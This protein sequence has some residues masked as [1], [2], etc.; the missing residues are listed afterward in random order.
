VWLLLFWFVLAGQVGAMPCDVDNDGDIDL[1]DLT[2]I[3]KSILA[4]AAVTGQDDPRDPDQNGLINSIDGRLCALRCTRAK[5]STVN[6]APF[7]NAGPDQTVKVGD[8]VQLSG[9]ASSDPDGD[10]LRYTWTFK[11]HPLGSLAS[12]IDGLTVA[13]RFTA[14]KPGQY[15]IQLIVSDGK[16][17]SVP[18][19]V[20]VSTENS[21]PI[22]NAGPD[23][24]VR[25]G[26]LVMLN[27]GRSTDVDGDPLTYS[28]QLA[29]APPR[30]GATL[31]NPYTVN[32]TLQIDQ[33]GSYLIALTVSDGKVHG[34]PDSVTVA[35][36]N[37][38]PVA[39]PG[40]NQSIPL[41]ATITL[42]GSRSSDVD[43]NPLTFRWSLL[44]RSPGSAAVLSNPNSVTPSFNADAP[45]TYVAQLIVNDGS[46]D[47]APAS[48]TLT[49]ANAAPIANAGPDQSV[50]LGS[51]ATLDGSASRD[52][53]GAA[54]TY[55]WSLTG[56]PAGSAASLNGSGTVNP[57]F[58][59]D[60]PGNYIAQLIVGDGQLASAPDTVTLST[61]NSRP[62]ADAGGA[63]AVTAGAPVQLDGSASRDADGD[64]ITFTWS[65]TSLPPGSNAAIT[66]SHGVS[67]SFVP[68]LAGAYIA[69]LIVSDG[70]LN[71]VPATVVVT[72]SAANRKPVAVAEAIPTQT[73]VGSPV[74]LKGSASSDP[75]GDPLTWSW[76]IALRPGGSNAGIVSPTAA[77][78]SF[79]PDLPGIYTIQLIVRDG[80]A[81]S[82]P[83]LV[84]VEALAANH[85]PVITSTPVITA[86]VG[87]PY[88]YAAQAIDPDLGDVLTWSLL[89]APSG[90]SID[91]VSGLIAWTPTAADAGQLDVSVQVR[92]SAGLTARQ[93]FRIDVATGNRAPVA[94]DDSYPMTSGQ[95]VTV[96]ARGALANDSDP[97]GNP[98]TA[99]IAREPARGTVTLN[100]DGS[101]SYTPTPPAPVPNLNAR[102]KW[103]WTS[104]PV[105]PDSL[106]VVMTPSVIDLDADGIPDVVFGSTDSRGGGF[107]EIG[108]LRALSGADG[109]ELFT[110]TDTTL[111]INAFSQIAVADIDSDGRPEIILGDAS[112]NRLVAFE[113]DGT[114]KWRSPV[115]EDISWGGPAIADLDGDG[116]PEII[117]GRQVLNAD[118]SLRWTGTGGR[119]AIGFN[120][121]L[122]PLSVV[123]D[124][125]LDGIPEVVAGNT[126]Y[127]PDGTIKWQAPLT[128]GFV[129]LGNFDDDP[130]PEIVLVN[131]GGVFL[132][133]HDGTTKWGPVS[134]PG[135][136]SGGPPTVADFDGDGRPEIG[137]AG[138]ARY[139]VYETDGSVKWQSITQDVSSNVTG[140]SVF[141]FEGD[142]SAE[143]VYRDELKL[144]VYRGRDGTVLF[145]YPLSSCT[146]YE[147]MPIVDVDADGHAEIVASATNCGTFGPQRGI[148]VFADAG[149]G[150]APTRK[151]WNQHSYHITNVNE[152]GTIPRR[153]DI[154]W[155]FPGLNNF[156]LNAYAPRDTA[157]ADSFTYRAS[158]GSLQSNEATVRLILQRQNRQPVF[159]SAPPLT[160]TTGQSYTYDAN[161]IDPDA[162]DTLIFSLTTAPAGMTIHSTTGLISWAPTA[163]QVGSHPITVRVT[164]QGGL[165][166]DQGY[167][168]TVSTPA[169][170]NRAPTITS[171]APTIA[172]AGAAYTYPVTATDPDAGDV[173]TWSLTA[174]PTGMT[175]DPATG[176]I[177][178]TPAVGQVG[179]NTVSVRV[180]DQGGLFATEGFT[181]SVAVPVNQP[182]IAVDDTYA[183]D[184]GSSLVVAGGAP[185]VPLPIVT[186]HRVQV[187]AAM[188]RPIGLAFDA[189]GTLYV[190]ADE[191]SAFPNDPR[192]PG[193]VR[194]VSP[195]GG[196]VQPFG[197]LQDD[198][199]AL[200]VDTTGRISGTSG[201]LLVSGTT[202]IAHDSHLTAILPDG[203]TRRVL[204]PQDFQANA[205]AILFDSRGRLLMS[206]F[207]QGSYRVLVIAQGA[208]T[209]LVDLGSV[210]PWDIAVDA[211]DRIFVA[212]EDGIIRVFEADGSLVNA[213]FASGQPPMR[214]LT[215]DPGGAF[216]G[217]LY[218]I[219]G[220]GRLLRIDTLGN[221]TEVGSGFD[222]VSASDMVFGPDRALYVSEVGRG[223]VLR[224]TLVQTPATAGGVLANDSDPD[225]DGLNA[226][227]VTQPA[228][229]ILSFAPNGA[230]VYTPKAGFE[231][232]DSFSYKANDGQLD[233][234]VA[235]VTITVQPVNHPPVFISAPILSAIA[236]QPYSYDANATDPDAG[237]ALVFSLTTAPAGM[238]I[239]STTGLISWTPLV[240]E[241]G[242]QNVTVRVTDAGGLF[243]EQNFRLAIAA[244]VNRPPVAVDDLFSVSEGAS[245]S[246]GSGAV[247]AEPVPVAFGYRVEVYARLQAPVQLTFDPAGVLYAGYD[248]VGNS[249]SP[250]DPGFVRRIARGGTPVTNFGPQQT[251]PDAVVVD[252][253]GS[254][255]GVA[256]AVLVSGTTSDGSASHLSAILPDGTARTL[257]SSPQYVANSSGM[258]F[259]RRGRLL[260]GDTGSVAIDPKRVLISEGAV[261]KELFPVDNSFPVELAVDPAN[262]I[263]V[264]GFFGVIRIYGEDGAL[265]DPAFVSGLGGVKAM[266]FG[267]GGDFGNALYVV[268]G[269]GRLLRVGNGGQIDVLGTG[270]DDAMDIV[271]GPDF[272]MYLS[273]Y[274]RGR[275]LRITATQA[276]GA[277][278]SVLAN[279]T[280]PE[281]DVLNAILM[282]Q[283]VNGSLSFGTNGAFTYTPMAGFRGM[284]SFTYKANDG[285]LDSNVA[286]VTITVQPVNHPPV[287]TS[288]PI[289]SAI[290]GQP[291]SYDANATDPD[292][293]DALAY[294]LTTAPPG[295]QINP[296]TG[297]IDWTPAAAQIG[298]HPVTVRV[299]DPGGLFD[300]QSFSINVSAPPP[301]NLPPAFTSTPIITATVGQPY[302]YD[303]NSTDDLT[304]E[305]GNLLLNGSFEQSSVNGPLFASS[306]AITHWTVGGVTI[307]YTSFPY[308]WNASDGVFS[309]DLEG[310][311]GNNSRGTIFQAFATCPGQPYRVLFD[312]SGNPAS[313]PLVKRVQVT[314]AADSMT[315]EYDIGSVGWVANATTIRY[316]LKEFQFTATGASTTLE[317]GSLG[318]TG[319]GPVIDNVRVIPVNGSLAYSLPTAP[320]GMTIDSTT[321]LISWTPTDVQAGPQNVTVRVTDP[322][323]LTDEQSFSITVS[324]PPPVN[325]PPAFTSSPI[326]TATVG[327]P[328]TYDAGATDTNTGDT[329]TFSLPAAPAG[330]GINPATG[331][332]S[333]T[334]TNTQVGSQAVTVRVTDPGGLTDEQSFSIT[335]SA[336][337]PVNLPPAFTSTPATTATV[338]QPYAYDADATDPGDTL[339]YSLTTAP[340]GM[341]IAAATG[342][343]QWTPT[344]AQAGDH[345]VEVKVQ[346]AGGLFVTQPF[347]LTVSATAVCVPPP[348]GLISWW[349]GDGNTLDRA[350]ANDGLAENGASYAAGLVGQAFRFDGVDDL[351]RIASSSTVS[352]GGPFSVEFWFN[353][354]TTINVSTPN[355]M[356]LAKGRYLEGGFN[357]PVAIQVLGG[358]GRLLVRMPPAPA[359]VTTTGTWPAGTWQHIA[360]SW[361]GARYR[362]YV[363]GSEEAGLDN[364]FSIFDSSDPITLGNADGFAAGGFAGLLDEPTLYNRALTPAEVTA[365]HAARGLGK[366][367]ATYSRADAGPDQAVEVAATVSLDGSASRAFDGAALAYQW[368][369]TSRPANSTAILANP[370]TVSPSFTADKAGAYTLEL[371][372]S[373]AGRASAPDSVSITAAKVN[374]P[375]SIT[376][377]AITA[378][379][380][381]TAYT[382][383]VTASDPDPGDTLSF[384]L[385]T[386]PAG[387]SINA[388]SGLI[389]WTPNAGQIGSHPVSVR[390]QDQGGLFA[391]QIFLLIVVAAPVPVTVP[392]VVGQEQAAAQNAISAASLTVGTVTVAASDTV[393]AGRVISQNPAAG[394]VVNSGSAVALVVSS[395]PQGPAVT[396]IRVTPTA[397][398]LL[399]GQTQAFAATGIL[400]NG[401]SLP[402]TSGLTWTSS[403]PA[404]AS[405]DVNGLSTALSQGSTT[406]SASQGGIT[407]SATFTVAQSVPDA[408][409][410]IA[411]ITAPAD[412]ASIASAVPIVG[413]ASDANFLKYL[414]EIAPFETGVFS[415]LHVGTAPVTGGTLA[416]LDPTTLVNDLYV[417]RLTVI[418]KADNRTQTEIT[419]Q[420]TRDKK[421]GNFTLAF[422]DLNVPMAGIPISVVRSYDSRD[423][424]RGDF[425]IGWRLDVQSLRLR[426][427]G[428]PGD[429]WRINRTGGVLNRLYS[430]KETRAHKVAITLPDGKVEE[431]TLTPVPDSQRLSTLD[432]T[433][434]VYSP[435][436]QTSGR[437]QPVGGTDL[438]VVGAQPGTV[439]LLTPGYELYNPAEYEYTTP[440]GQVILISR[441]AGVKQIRDRSG[442]TVSFAPGGIIHSAGKSITFARDGQGRITTVTDP[443]G[444]AQTYA[445]DINGDLA[446]HTDAEGR[447]T[448]F[449]YN[450]EHGLIEIQDPRGV[451]PIRNEYDAAGRLIKTIDAYGKEITYTHDL[452][453]NRE[454]I[455]DR[456]GNTTI[457]VYDDLGNVTQTADPLG[458]VTNRSYDGRGNTLSET[459]PLGRT[460]T[461]TY[462]GQD[463][464]LT[465]TDPLGQTTRYTYNNSRQVLT[466]T[467]AL[468]RITSNAYDANGNLT[469]STDPAG[470][471]TTYTYDAR[472][473]QNTRTDP[474]GQITS[475]AYDASGNLASETDA[476]GRVTSYTY[477]ANGNRLT[478]S[479]T[480]S[481][482]GGPETLT[483]R[484][485]YDK[486]NRL[487]ET[488]HPD[489]S[490][491]R[492]AYN[493]I[494]KQSVTTDPL[495]RETKF[496]YD[497]MGRL[498]RSTYPDGSSE[499]S[500]YDAEGRRTG[501][502]DR[503]GRTTT[504]T[505][506]QL[507][508]LIET[509]A[510]D[511]SRTR[512]TY[513]AAGQVLASTDARGNVTGYEY[514]AAGRRSKVTD[515]AGAATLFTY[516]AL[517]NQ[518]QVTDANGHS[519]G[520]QY[521]ANNRRTRTNYADGTFELVVYDALG[522]QTA[523]T[524]QAGVTTQYGY[525][526][527]GRLISVTDALGQVTRYS[528][529]EQGNQ[530][531]QTDAEGRTTSFAY[532]KMGRRIRRTLP[533][534]QTETFSYD[535]AGNLRTKTDFNGRTTS[536]T[537]DT[538]NRLTRKTPD[539]SLGQ[540]PVVFSYTPSGQRAS[541]QDASGST[542]YSYDNR[543]RLLSKATPQ[544]TLSYSYDPAGNLTRIQSNHAGGAAMDYAYDPRN[545]LATVTD[546]EGR[547]TTYSYDA[548]GNLAGFL[549]PN[550]VQTTYTYNPLNRLTNVTGA[551]GGT[552]ASYTYTLGPSGNRTAVTEAS[553]RRVDY[554]YDDLYRLRSETI[555]ADPTGPNGAIAYTYDRVG[556]RLTRISTVAG[557]PEQNFNYDFND[558]LD[559]E[560]YDNN[561]NTLTS[562]G[563]TFGYDFE[564]HL[565]SADGGVTFVYDGDGIRVA[566][567]AGG[568]TTGFLVDDRNPTGYAQVL[569]ELVGGAVER[570]Y[571]YG[572]KLISQKQASGVSFYGYDGHGSV[573]YLTD[574]SGNVT[575]TYSYE[576]FGNLVGQMSSTANVYLYA[577]EQRD[578]DVGFYYL[579]ARYHNSMQGRFLS[580]DP[581]SGVLF[582]PP[583]LHRYLYTANDPIGKA[584]PTGE[585]YTLTELGLVSAI[586]GILGGLST[587]V[588]NYALGR[589][590]TKASLAV[591][592]VTGAALGPLS[593]LY[594]E[595]GALA[596]AYG[597]VSSLGV[598]VEVFLS[599]TST[600]GQKAAAGALVLATVAGA[601]VAYK[602]L[603]AATGRVPGLPPALIGQRSV[604]NFILFM[605]QN[606]V[607]VVASEIFVRSPFQPIGRR[608]DVVLRD[609]ATQQL[610]GIEIKA[611]SG[612]FGRLNRA[613]ALSDTVVLRFGSRAFG[614]RARAAGIEGEPIHNVYRIQ[615]ADE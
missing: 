452:G 345:P 553:G 419:V 35:T 41:G 466:V 463:N 286:V 375:P 2:L 561:G 83:A 507:G 313:F 540:P 432:A 246:V 415:T 62:V 243:A 468:G 500:A 200:I 367:T 512:T 298:S 203:T 54:L 538:V 417:V 391:P 193:F 476:L 190:G 378:G 245:I 589:P 164:D 101:F 152:D 168:I 427:T 604:D 429:G 121:R 205:S 47:S 438:I 395:G 18:D 337:P 511:G 175:I 371:I 134:I 583:S 9:A 356:L 542:T 103:S 227:L 122:G 8:P 484:F 351:I 75:D 194:R 339:T 601:A 454:L 221:T 612:A 460:R 532:D 465:E 407:G 98:I 46:V 140:S 199:D 99:S 1:N 181:V 458:G 608:F 61:T 13:P 185:A 275:V 125:D 31:S 381:G 508:R 411:E 445:Y 78:T 252:V 277:Q 39:N 267:T 263:F 222:T 490:V 276:A 76:S 3:Q 58:T 372:V 27:G 85:P 324:A 28:W 486:A 274:V 388:A 176:L 283:P 539:G 314:A 225:G 340:P 611:T 559:G 281:G 293:G 400:A 174:A 22:A 86:T 230:F 352:F 282:T 315:F 451:R 36:E 595:I 150:W 503:A 424:T 105:L 455:T 258:V 244:P 70:Q 127:R 334:P 433:S 549:Y 531:T 307:D 548:V 295:M 320:A 290:A 552:L 19:T 82:V 289:L 350:A 296:A 50:P 288:A 120:L 582:D 162:A 49:T 144:R 456:L 514:D 135:G 316:V 114:F 565:T 575:D 157:Q 550:G 141:D 202:E 241:A 485:T 494:G 319:Y 602:Y 107:V 428:I 574:V 523:K 321:G 71:S 64:P 568:V 516:D 131:G 603:D 414:I 270:F 605:R 404:V 442:N 534:G 322:G 600:P 383:P 123:A 299:T 348:A 17:D 147:Y 220:G 90:M 153:E 363:N 25:V 478:Q 171:T 325:L 183:V 473:L 60:R 606:N 262:R 596:V 594:A 467:D 93:D 69:Q 214:A 234:N 394:S 7:A 379:A 52:P 308:H 311:N 297:V 330:M 327:Q 238:T 355:Q 51:S 461:T 446:S 554:T 434:A 170:T 535:A 149:P 413:T 188:E 551:R 590:T 401:S 397:P 385:T 228:S 437:L 479:T 403:N 435:G 271:F 11:N 517:G 112:G 156:R 247:P 614:A 118:G 457:H 184:E 389:Q 180:Q 273:E 195:G 543:D 109:R 492:V 453:A 344:A 126:V 597:T 309:I 178:W 365:L 294:S 143:V 390:V 409:L 206:D 15:L 495:G 444:N 420:I 509:I 72:V 278:G 569:E 513:D 318:S 163:A 347:T 386:A 257:F 563:R 304:C 172:T 333:W 14:D 87:Q 384:S 519:I 300:E 481:T 63:Q 581:A 249:P 12:L 142:G 496:D 165:F 580:N 399:T 374:H 201:A 577:G 331:L 510:P 237:D 91:P 159:T 264:A 564:N 233:S 173:L 586:G 521:D 323:G 439:Q 155:L 89:T 487:T 240:G 346:D 21:R 42:D 566:K 138:A 239:N 29:S 119:G 416:T 359:L 266:A 459:D 242:N 524:D 370:T 167:G 470:Q 113:H 292:A 169:P 448:S 204:G 224:I 615:W 498:T 66:P 97:D 362:L 418:D 37:S 80:K 423:K 115:L 116:Q 305:N 518:I 525:D 398:L 368:T 483:T 336:P 137:V 598:G 426:V 128:D 16:L 191:I 328:Y 338:G 536:Y 189:A 139:V 588:A 405:I 393:A 30:S 556:N 591:G 387:M 572:L 491:T 301:V 77:Q 136:G 421:V 210:A 443:M 43:G 430:L 610:V 342:L 555:S 440:E 592:I 557:I 402:L 357:A 198:P 380:V 450:Y 4:R 179:A 255:T 226:I 571:T 145:E 480:R 67:P 474:L 520:F 81:D 24:S 32:P 537:Y 382:Y 213:S 269:G 560:G 45:G 545:R 332:I 462:D 68:D 33:P 471:A 197:P 40:A 256:G 92:D 253:Q 94:L 229:G 361:D 250:Y 475:Y 216:A 217:H 20:I 412:G 482:A 533:L 477:D 303:V 570:S 235:M 562:G 573:R 607:E 504:S 74:V 95:P 489:G 358:D 302:T 161:A 449:L 56:R 593:L 166:A 306:T 353:P 341:V 146:G 151:I 408:T 53:E 130:F 223:Q 335:V 493:A 527:L 410:P 73:T 447:R 23:Q 488:T 579:R 317:F 599:D 515:A 530:L 65:L 5:C 472:G 177:A 499:T 505:Y 192:D 354:T 329:L 441:T 100:A 613:Q 207:L 396:A 79:V 312:L 326:T 436:A 544:G 431:F 38:P 34:L 44:A 425:G 585:K 182:P 88:S 377:T 364:A 104:S 259:D 129:A 369:L 558:R 6:Q 261:P 310:S 529:D 576:A 469:S 187:Y 291:Y 148:H 108:A 260:I 117:M 584:D 546:A 251:D 360:L 218:G 501:S 10:P 102:L 265:I 124:T 186:G 373:N 609:P 154:N 406:I 106:N 284:D 285:Q 366:C 541:M 502:T 587:R 212:G 280:D 349:P 84:V 111:A 59:L 547:V 528:Y 578:G 287:F 158:D 392:D 232:T 215:F 254:I 343:I 236:G 268:D 506:D 48:V 160:V 422:Q 211:N 57:S 55:T 567:T 272:A 376:S 248:V 279:D 464:R 132:L 209:P 196:T 96:P 133:E 110:V 522:R 26:T 526:A 497:D 208:A 231:G 219:D